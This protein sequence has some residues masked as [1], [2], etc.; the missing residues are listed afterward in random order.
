ML[1]LK[2]PLEP[3]RQ[4][5]WEK[6]HSNKINLISARFAKAC[7]L[8]LWTI[9]PII[10]RGRK[11]DGRTGRRWVLFF[12]LFEPKSSFF[13]PNVRRIGIGF[14]HKKAYKERI[15]LSSSSKDWALEL[16]II[17]GWNG[18]GDND[19]ILWWWWTFRQLADWVRVTYYV[20]FC[21][22]LYC[23]CHSRICH[24]SLPSSSHE[25]W[26]QGFKAYGSYGCEELHSYSIKH[27]S[28]FQTLVESGTLTKGR[29]GPSP[30]DII[31]SP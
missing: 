26:P 14:I 15:R 29:S 20:R 22:S 30:T 11:E 6:T 3:T 5:K 21:L 12:Y 27:S 28:I 13:L 18:P 10:I 4:S 7:L 19:G 2:Q 16:I 1:C 8:E 9:F 23:H 24:T 17:M 25:R 31:L